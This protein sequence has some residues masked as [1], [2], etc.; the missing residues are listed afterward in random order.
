MKG[1]DHEGVGGL[2]FWLLGLGFSNKYTKSAPELLPEVMFNKLHLM[3]NM[4][5]CYVSAAHQ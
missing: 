2:G 3:H 4:L 5:S 1:I